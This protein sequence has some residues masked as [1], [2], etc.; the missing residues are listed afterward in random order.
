MPTRREWLE[1]TALAALT[2]AV[3]G[4]LGAELRVGPA[5]ER[6]YLDL[7][8]RAAD[9]IE[10]SRR[11]TEYGAA[12]P[13]DPLRPES[14]S[15]DLYNGMP[16][17]VVFL[18]ELARATGDDRWRDAAG[19]GAAHLWHAS[20][21]PETELDTGLYSGLAGLAFTFM[22]LSDLTGA[23]EDVARA[24]TLL[25]EL[26]RR[27]RRQ[28]EAVEWNGS[29][30]IISGNSGVA[31]LLLEAHRRWG[32]A[33]HLALAVQAGHG[34]IAAG[35]PAQGGTMWY[36]AREFRRNYP[37]F[38]HGTAGVAYALATLYERTGETR[39]LEAALQGARYLDAIAT[40]EG[41][42]TLIF[43][44][45]DGGEDLYYLSWCHGPPG[46]VR[47]FTRLQRVTGDAR[48]GEWTD[49]LTRGLFAS[50]VPETRTPGFWENISQCCGNVGV[51]EYMLDLATFAPTPE[52][53]RM[54]ERVVAD[55]L[56]RASSNTDD[57]LRWIQAENRTEPE[58]LVAQTGYMQGAAGVGSFLL[59][60][61]AFERDTTRTLRF[62]D[63]PYGEPS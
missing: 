33:A 59:R 48:W 15:F 58:N 23:P 19:Q 26:A 8:V 6:R 34:L 39:F 35:E 12:W 14:V 2:V 10:S 53:R 45:E 50:G 20:R 51:G 43:H 9:W 47:L 27:A 29:Y 57:G 1:Q 18:A 13:A 54:V 44:H 22:T 62:P 40:R 63:T 41:D 4:T 11:A 25:D 31:L 36:P 5:R 60:L 49:R 52:S 37:N 56:A 42:R 32:D 16:G 30:D 46:T 3:P 17:V 28:G 21:S 61:D 38:S 24:R 55:T 7:A